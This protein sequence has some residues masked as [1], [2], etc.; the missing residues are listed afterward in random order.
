M[1]AYSTNR[2][3]GLGTWPSK[4]HDKV[5]RMVHFD[6]PTF[7]PEIGRTSFG[8]IEFSEDIPGEDL[9]A[10]EMK[11]PDDSDEVPEMIVRTLWRH[12]NAGNDEAFSKAWAKAVAKGYGEDELAD[13]FDRAYGRYG[14]L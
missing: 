12:T 9:D 4:H 8:Y 7:V 6:G 5:V 10:Y 11:V 14:A 3:I 2:P 1:I 13:A